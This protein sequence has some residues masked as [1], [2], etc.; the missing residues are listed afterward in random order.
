VTVDPLY[1]RGA[2]TA[3]ACWAEYART[4]PGA[5]VQRLPGVDAAVFAS[6]P[7]REVFN[8]AILAHGLAARER[9][10]ALD[11]MARAY[12]DAGVTSFAAWVHESDT[13]MRSDLADR[14]YL[15]HETTW[16][17]GRTL[18]D[19][20]DDVPDVEPAPADWAEYLRVLELPP[21]LLTTVDPAA[22]HVVLGRLDGETVATAM[23]FDHEDDCGLYNVGTLPHARR[24]G[25]AHALTVL[26]L[27]QARARGR[28]TAT[29]Q[30]TDAARRVYAAAGFRDLGR[31]LE[32]RRSGDDGD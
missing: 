13:A 29:L 9:S 12:A 24:R 20:P 5:A 25:L 18:D 10:R 21:G 15:V 28:R 30:S 8:N 31:I 23:A 27:Q 32:H 19:V 6:G 3:V 14:G 11:A 2:A 16:A 1:L 7:E 26:Q 4:V 17:M 22:F